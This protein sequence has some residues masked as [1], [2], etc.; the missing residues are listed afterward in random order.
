MTTTEEVTGLSYMAKHR[1]CHTDRVQVYGN[2][3]SYYISL[4]HNNIMYYASFSEE[5]ITTLILSMTKSI[6]SGGIIATDN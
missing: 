3:S 5:G 1:E 2:Y 4:V 6:S